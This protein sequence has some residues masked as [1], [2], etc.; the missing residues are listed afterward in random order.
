MNIK[1][2]QYKTLTEKDYEQ[3]ETNFSAIAKKYN[4]TVKTCFE[5]RNLTEYGFI[6]EDCLS[7]ELAYYLTS[8]KYKSW[9]SR[10]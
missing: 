10:K 3:I 6:K 9:K 5:D 2:L 1:I 8:K 4:M 7:H